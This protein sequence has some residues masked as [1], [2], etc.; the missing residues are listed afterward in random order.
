MENL[1]TI[2][3]NSIFR[4]P[5]YQRGYSWE[6]KHRK[7]LWLDIM[8]L[9]N[10]TNSVR[11]KHYMGPISVEVIEREIA[12]KNYKF[13]EHI[14]TENTNFYWVVD[15]QQR[16]LT[17]VI[18]LSSI[19]NTM[20]SR[21]RIGRHT[22]ETLK[23]K[24]LN[25]KEFPIISYD[26]SSS[27]IFLS[28][29]I[30]GIP[31]HQNEDTRTIYTKN[32]LKTKEYF[33][34]KLQE[35]F[36]NDDLKRKL[37]E[38]ITERFMFDFHKFN[39]KEMDISII[40]ETMNDRGKPLSNLEKLKN[41]L[42]YLSFIIDKNFD[43]NEIN[44]TW[45]LIYQ[46]LGRNENL[47]PQLRDD[48]FLRDHWIKYKRFDKKGEFYRRDI[49]EKFFV[50]S[51]I[52]EQSKEEDIYQ[53]ST[54]DIW[55]QYDEN[56][57][58]LL[59]NGLQVDESIQEEINKKLT[60][61][62]IQEYHKDLC[63]SINE[64]YKVRSPD[65]PFN[66]TEKIK[67]EETIFWLKKLN[68]IGF[69]SFTPLIV[70]VF[71][72]EQNQ[73]K[74][75]KLL[76][77]MESFVFLLFYISI[78]RSQ[79]GGPHFYRKANEYSKNNEISIEVITDDI[80]INW[81][82]GKEKYQGY[83]DL[84]M[85]SKYIYDKFS[86][87]ASP[88]LGFKSWGSGERGIK[89]FLAEYE[90]YL[91]EIELIINGLSEED[92]FKQLNKFSFQDLKVE[93]VEDFS[94]EIFRDIKRKDKREAYK[95]NLTY[96]LGNLVLKTDGSRSLLMRET[97]K[98][99]GNWNAKAVYKRGLDLLAFMEKRWNFSFDDWS[100]DKKRLLMLEDIV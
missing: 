45:N 8:N 79:V 63:V 3:N 96:S 100:I 26:D 17:I 76:K 86:M 50:L 65:Q 44:I 12:K 28:K 84:E 54:D 35:E 13:D 98:Q 23:D 90:L 32:L 59:E 14:Y 19:L 82:Y 85:F 22:V 24:Y 2:F 91:E 95:K 43:R 5:V 72:K 18:L 48:D 55:G 47:K 80:S 89:Y 69:R 88:S 57:D 25:Y 56:E 51:R 11:R 83:L 42:M 75:S 15:G 46:H 78:R 37:F 74:I 73:I 4:I 10:D 68:F 30:I 81:T 64:W 52:N 27:H 41:R 31:L 67:S 39:N 58:A 92:I 60:I 7:S 36:K 77:A 49:F 87:K 71:Q 99:Y 66:E 93:V 1:D 20:D 33:Q 34:S 6:E 16:L 40:F 53:E 29:E 21:M 9:V 70:A 97:L 38:T 94:E 61:D 62:E